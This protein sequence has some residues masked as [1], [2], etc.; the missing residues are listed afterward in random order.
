M[1]QPREKTWTMKRIRN[2]HTGKQE[3]ANGKPEENGEREQQC[4]KTDC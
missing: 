4:A 3:E 1:K 2:E